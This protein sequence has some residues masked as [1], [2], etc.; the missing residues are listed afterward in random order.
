MRQMRKKRKKILKKMEVEEE[1][2]RR[3][4]KHVIKYNQEVS[5]RKLS[6][7]SDTSFS[8]SDDE[9]ADPLFKCPEV[10]SRKPAGPPAKKKKRDEEK[11]WVNEGSS[12]LFSEDE[13]CCSKV[14]AKELKRSPIKMPNGAKWRRYAFVASLRYVPGKPFN[15]KRQSIDENEREA[16]VKYIEDVKSVIEED[17]TEF[18]SKPLRCKS[19]RYG[20]PCNIDGCTAEPANYKRHLQRFHKYTEHHAES[21]NSVKIRLWGYI[22]SVLRS[23]RPHICP[24]CQQMVSRINKHLDRV[25]YVIVDSEQMQKEM[26]KA[27]K[28]SETYFKMV[29]SMNVQ[30]KVEDRKVESGGG[31]VGLGLGLVDNIDFT[32][33]DVLSGAI[34]LDKLKCRRFKISKENF[35]LYYEDPDVLLEDFRVWQ[36]RLCQVP[37]QQSKT[38][39]NYINEIWECVDAARNLLPCNSLGLAAK[40]HL[41]YIL[42]RVEALQEWNRSSKSK[43]EIVKAQKKEPL[44]ASALRNRTTV[45]LRFLDFLKSWSIFAGITSADLA[46]CQSRVNFEINKQLRTLQVFRSVEVREEKVVNI[47]TAEESI[48]YGKSSHIQGLKGLLFQVKNN[49]ATKIKVMQVIYVRNFL[50]YMLSIGNGLRS[51]NLIFFLPSRNTTKLN[52]IMK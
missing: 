52:W 48:A 11:V 22:T 10:P 41:A 15:D 7:D 32:M 21:L 39:K 26:E 2:I 3:L 34:A 43:K 20:I 1:E 33:P 36:Y 35:K 18:F 9:T 14:T 44:L 12:D 40:I 23:H 8:E 29:P 49:P 38:N 16:Y 4:S 28:L 13:P 25:H 30:E 42:P 50:M 47:I 27:T 31:D 6:S 19:R 45:Y 17:V 37:L 5:F 46:S 24:I 51:S